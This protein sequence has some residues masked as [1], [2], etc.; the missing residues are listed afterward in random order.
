MGDHLSGAA[1]F[2]QNRAVEN[3]TKCDP[4]YG[5]RLREKLSKSGKL[6]VIIKSFKKNVFSTT[7]DL[8]FFL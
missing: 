6:K 7:F 2:I 3:F 4:D 5:R 8:I 1:E